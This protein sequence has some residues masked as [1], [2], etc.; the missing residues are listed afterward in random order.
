[1]LLPYSHKTEARGGIT[2][3]VISRKSIT[4]PEG[5]IAGLETIQKHGTAHGTSL[6]VRFLFTNPSF[7][8][9]NCLRGVLPYHIWYGNLD[10][11]L[12]VVAVKLRAGQAQ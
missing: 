7:R 6:L 12:S 11:R 2:A 9:G 8:K 5:K 1:M 3:H 4:V 10:A